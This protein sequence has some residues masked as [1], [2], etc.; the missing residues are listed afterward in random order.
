MVSHAPAGH[1]ANAG[2]VPPPRTPPLPLT[3]SLRTQADSRAYPLAKDN[4]VNEIQNLVQQAANYK[5][6]KKGANEGI[7]HS[8]A[9]VHA[10]TL[11]H[12][13]LALSC[14][15]CVLPKRISSRPHGRVNVL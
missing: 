4:L 12:S 3:P 11:T 1:A 13:P 10:H 14:H 2:T 5:Q 6:L 9:H 7:S 8:H 15:H